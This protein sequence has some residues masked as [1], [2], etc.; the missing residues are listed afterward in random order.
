M[1][2]GMK[3]VQGCFARVLFCLAEALGAA[4][5]ILTFNDVLTILRAAGLFKVCDA[6]C[7]VRLLD[8]LTHAQDNYGAKQACIS[9]M[10]VSGIACHMC[11][12]KRTE[13]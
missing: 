13:N 8:V 2:H 4:D 5:C 7:R 3:G 6:G 10:A 1:L 11:L 9:Y 12:R